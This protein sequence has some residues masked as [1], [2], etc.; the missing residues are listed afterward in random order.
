M[1]LPL[2]SSQNTC[3]LVSY[4]AVKITRG[5]CTN[6]GSGFIVLALGREKHANISQRRR[7]DTRVSY[8]WVEI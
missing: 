7:L 2:W 6:E 1:T 3:L 8:D 5:M 4:A